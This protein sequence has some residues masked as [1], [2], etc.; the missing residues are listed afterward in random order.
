MVQKSKEGEMMKWL[1]NLNSI[2]TKGQPGTCPHCKRDTLIKEYQELMKKARECADE[3]EKNI[4]LKKASDKHDEILMND[5]GRDK[6][7]K[8]FNT[9]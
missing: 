1:D 8:R 4:L 2:A 7:F 6:N 9:M 3:S 5:M